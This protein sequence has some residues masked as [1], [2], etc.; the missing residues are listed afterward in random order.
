MNQQ[1]S[2]Q[3]IVTSTAESHSDT[4]CAMAEAAESAGWHGS[5]THSVITPGLELLAVSRAVQGNAYEAGLECSECAHIPHI[6]V[7][8]VEVI[9]ETRTKLA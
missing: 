3:K 4:C 5:A 8:C 2:V 7:T 9:H 1:N 6:E